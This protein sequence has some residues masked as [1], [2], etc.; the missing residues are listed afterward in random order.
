MLVGG[1][2]FHA[3]EEVEAL[4]NALTAI[5]WPDDEL[6]VFATLRGPLFA[7]DDDALLAF[8]P[9]GATFHP[10]RPPSLRDQLPLGVS[11]RRSLCFFLKK[12]KKK[13]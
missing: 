8:R 6:S 4:R 9:A 3:R 12:K 2:R 11:R 10:L 5:E 7:L 13:I 1:K